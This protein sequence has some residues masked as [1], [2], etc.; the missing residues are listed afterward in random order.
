MSKKKN[1]WEIKCVTAP[2]AKL[3]LDMV[4]Y[5]TDF[6][7]VNKTLT[8]EERN[9]LSVAYKNKIGARRSSWRI[10]SSE[11]LRTTDEEKLEVLKKYKEKVGAELDTIY[12]TVLELI[13]D[14]LIP[15]VKD[16]DDNESKVFYYKM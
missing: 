16:S 13:D 11:E 5:M 6:V 12:L 14:I 15:G 7:K 1:R 8:S 4:E 3:F 9:L 2:F 10:L